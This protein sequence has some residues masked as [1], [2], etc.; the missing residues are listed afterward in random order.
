M[1]RDPAGPE[2]RAALA[3]LG[4]AVP[5]VAPSPGLARYAAGDFAEAARLLRAALDLDARDPDVWAQAAMAF[6]EAGQNGEAAR[7]IEDGR[8]IFFDYPPLLVAATYEALARGDAAAA[9]TYVLQAQAALEDERIEDADL[10]AAAVQVAAAYASGAVPPEAG[11]ALRA[12]ALV[13][14]PGGAILSTLGAR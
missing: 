3:E 10:V 2:V 5:E 14:A 13:P 12:R 11:G 8:L 4:A 7:V 1:L 9:R 6:L